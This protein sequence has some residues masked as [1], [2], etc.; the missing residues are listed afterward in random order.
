MTVNE[1]LGEQFF[2][3]TTAHQ[4]AAIEETGLRSTHYGNYT[5]HRSL[6]AARSYGRDVAGYDPEGRHGVISVQIPARYAAAYI[7]TKPHEETPEEVDE[8]GNKRAWLH[9]TIPPRYITRIE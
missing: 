1:H 9:R 7:E 8:G 4:A 3:G 5:L 6:E 2:H